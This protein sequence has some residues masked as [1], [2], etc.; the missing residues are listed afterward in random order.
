MFTHDSGKSHGFTCN[1]IHGSDKMARSRGRDAPDEDAVIELSD[2]M[3][4]IGA[5]TCKDGTVLISGD[6]VD[7][8]E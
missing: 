3:F 1:A 7:G 2:E 8:I 4:S 6:K 5:L